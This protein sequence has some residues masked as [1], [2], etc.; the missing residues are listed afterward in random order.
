MGMTQGVVPPLADPFATPNAATRE[1]PIIP[2]DHGAVDA[3]GVRSFSLIVQPGMSRFRNGVDTTTLGYNGA[4]LG[5]ALKLRTGEETRIRVQNGLAEATTTHWHGLFVPAHVD[6]GPHQAIAP[7]AAWQADFTVANPAS[8]CWFH[9]HVHGGTGR[10]VVAGLAGLLIIDDALTGPST[11]P[12]TWGA[13]DLA[14]VLQDKRFTSSGQID[15]TLGASDRLNGY[16]GD[17]LLVNGVIGPVWQSPRQWIRLRLLNGCNARVLSVRLSDAA[18][19][20]QVA[21]EGGLL[22]GPV[23]RTSVVLAPGER[24][25]VLVDFGGAAVGQEISLVARTMALAVG[26]G[27]GGA[28]AGAEVTAMKFR[29]SLPRQPDAMLSPPA[30]LPASPPVVAGAGAAVRSFSLDGGM[31]GGTFTINSRSFDINRT[32]FV[33]PANAVEVWRFYNATGM[34][35]PMHVHGVKMSLLARNGAPPPAYE[36]GLRDTFVVAPMETVTV[37][38]QTAAVASP[39]PL[40][41]HCHI[42]EHED[43]GMMGQFVTV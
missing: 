20:L 5:P 36:Q 33:A 10:Q 25:E 31:M 30:T 21:N 37:A 38:V 41:F 6:G 32:D 40:M 39:S 35:H 15:Y 8:T 16:M 24:A 27:M 1:L 23:A 12:D 43:A 19:M 18:A 2:L 11:L 28:A 9:P 13:D 4:L 17:S 14:L 42:L 34:T 26:I 3:S 22:S 7:G 29:V